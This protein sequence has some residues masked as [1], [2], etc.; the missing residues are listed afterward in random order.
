MR[1]VFF[2]SGA[3]AVGRIGVSKVLGTDE[4]RR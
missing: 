2:V 1:E 3:D 4:G